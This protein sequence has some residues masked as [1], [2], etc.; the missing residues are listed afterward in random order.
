MGHNSCNIYNS[1]HDSVPMAVINAQLVQLYFVSDRLQVAAAG[2]GC[3]ECIY[4]SVE[5]EDG[6][7]AKPKHDDQTKQTK[8]KEKERQKKKKRAKKQTETEYRNNSESS[9]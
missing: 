7:S 4:D 9:P 5:S 1:R 8:R 6:K 2:T 3:T